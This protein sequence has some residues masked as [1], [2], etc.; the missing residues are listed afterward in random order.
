V[1]A[2]IQTGGKQYKVTQGDLIKVER[3]E[4]KVGDRVS[5]DDVLLLSGEDGTQVGSPVVEGARVV[6]KIV[7]QSKGKKV[8]VFKFKRRKM[9]RRLRGHRQLISDIRIEDI[10]LEGT[11]DKKEPRVK[12]TGKARTRAK[13]AGQPAAEEKSAPPK[14]S[15]KKASGKAEGSVSSEEGSGIE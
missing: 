5:F 14:A 13:S 15:R 6:G 11:S 3:L 12:E 4:G 8:L 7:E 10:E 9:Y 1:Y 2:V